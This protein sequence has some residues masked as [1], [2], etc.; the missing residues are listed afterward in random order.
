MTPAS[1]NEVCVGID[2]GTTSVKAIAADADGNVVARARVPHTI[3]VPAPDRMEHDARAAWFRGPVRA[4]GSLRLERQPLAVSVAAMV[5]SMAAVD[6][7]GR[8]VS[9]G[10][11]YGD[12]RGRASGQDRTAGDA[13][14]A[15][16][17][18]GWL[19]AHYPD[20]HGYWPAQAVANMALGGV[21]AIDG[22]TAFS[23]FPLY[24]LEGWDEDVLDA[25]GTSVAQ[26]PRVEGN[27]QPIGRVG[28]A[29]LAA[30]GID[31]MGEQ[32]V[33]AADE[34]GDVLAILGTTLIVWV[35]VDGHPTVPGL[36]SIP[37]FH[38]QSRSLIGGPSNA[39]GL[40]LNWARRLFGA[41]VGA[42]G[43]AP[44]PDDPRRVPVFAPYVRGER[45][46]L[47]DPDRRAAITGL[48]LNHDRAAILRA[49]Y[50]SSGFTVHHI[51][52]RAVAGAGAAPRRIVATGGGTRDP[53]WLQAISDAANLPIDVVAV[54]E[55]GAL[56]AA[57]FARMA[58]GFETSMTDAA[59]WARTSHRVEP[60]QA[61]AAAM[62]SRY[63]TFRSL[64]R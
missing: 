15:V 26:L 19:A 6:N 61:W 10:L 12:A 14:E 48:D 47:H 56:G 11:L 4:L 55:G 59:R 35:V 24:G 51:L 63:E 44:I 60:D 16:A 39:G 57:W 45:V 34:P 36:W 5:P 33:A 30:P 37:S 21:P 20:A 18:L 3:I 54:P 49:A 43:G 8:P 28:G 25:T 2:I 62:A 58:A 7:K 41:R 53:Q 9:P 64:A 17:F 38:D 42:R 50:E 52:E 31:A 22:S 40:F 23:S 13:G 32:L 1:E 27:G 29:I 46:P